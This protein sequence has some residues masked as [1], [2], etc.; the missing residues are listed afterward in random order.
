MMRA[1]LDTNVLVSAVIKQGGKPYRIITQALVRFE[2]LTCD[3]I[4]HE[5]VE[6]LRRKHI[7]TKYGD[8]VTPKSCD[9][10]L[11][12]ART[13]ATVVEVKTAVAVV[14]ADSKDNPV[15]ACAKDGLAH[16]VVTGDPHLLRLETFEGVKIVTPA[17]FL[18]IL[19]GEN[20]VLK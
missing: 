9:R 2:W 18:E 8:R 14:A 1:V 11:E 6:V 15:L 17:Q 3:F 12:M 4:L 10:F 20:G 13:I 7:Q 16:Y 5:L 19:E